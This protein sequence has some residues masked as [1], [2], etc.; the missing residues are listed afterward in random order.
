MKFS[1]K[2][3]SNLEFKGLKRGCLLRS[4]G[5]GF[6]FRREVEGQASN[7]MN[8]IKIMDYCFCIIIICQQGQGDKGKR[9]GNGERY[10]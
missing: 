7:V 5:V 4:F 10:V 6:I 3:V 1:W 8:D 9:E 2:K